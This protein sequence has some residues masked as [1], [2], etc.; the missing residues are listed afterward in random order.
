MSAAGL[1]GALAAIAIYAGLF[2]V[3]RHGAAHG[4][5]GFDQTA[6]RFAVSGLLVLPFAWAHAGTAARRLGAG[7]LLA[8]FVLGGAPY[9]AVFLGGLVFAPAAYGA[10]LVPGLQPL[11]V[12]AIAALWL[13]QRPAMPNLVGALVCLGGL[14]LVL[15][16]TQH[17]AAPGG[18]GSRLLIGVALFVLSAALWGGYA[19]ALKAWKVE[20]REVLATTAPLSALL[21]VPVYLLWHG[22]GPVMAAPMEALLLQVVYQ[23]GLVGVA[24]LVLYAWAVKS[25]GSAA[26]A[27]LAPA[28]P[29]MAAL[30]GL[31]FLGEAPSPLQWAGLAVVTTGLL[32]GTLWPWARMPRHRRDRALPPGSDRAGG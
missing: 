31:F 24:A 32:A 9:S 15:L 6:I 17:L 30:F 27:A 10:A 1:L 5:D 3:G 19:V 18:T 25:A 29:V 7:R 26:V 13:A 16:D 12:M 8:L 28:M 20:P 4:L 11:A 2:T 21:Y 22:A 14:A 23:G